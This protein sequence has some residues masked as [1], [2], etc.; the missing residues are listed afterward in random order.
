MK[1]QQDDTHQVPPQDQYGQSP[2]PQPSQAPQQPPTAAQPQYVHVAR[3]MSP[4]EVHIPEE[5]R[6]RHQQSKAQYPELNLSDGEYV[7]SAIRRHPIGLIEI[8]SVV[9]FV[10]LLALVALPLYALNQDALGIDLP[11]PSVMAVPL[12]VLAVL[13]ALG[14]VVA[15]I[16]YRGNKFFLTNES[17]IQIIRPSLFSTHEQTVSLANIEDASYRR[18][19]LLQTALNYGALRLSTEGDETTYR[20]NYVADPRQQVATLN[21][22]VEAFKNGRPVDPNDN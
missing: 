17:V 6:K 16:V 8:W 22:A 4:Q 10:L 21:N 20:F 13:F 1:P 5:A 14:G 15:T 3:P 19:G 12:L 11:S 18:Q 2:Q 9:G 7:I